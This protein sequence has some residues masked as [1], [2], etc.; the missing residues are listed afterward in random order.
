MRIIISGYLGRMGQIIDEAVAG[1]P[2]MEVVGGIDVKEASDA[3]VPVFSLP[4]GEDTPDADLVIDFS[5]FSLTEALMDFCIAKKIP[6]VVATTALGPD[7]K[8]ALAKAAETLPI[9][10]TANMSLGINLL[11]KMLRMASPS[12]ENDFNIEIV[13]KHHKM[14]ADA[15]SGTAVMLADVVN[16]SLKTPKNLL[17]GRHGKDYEPTMADLGIHA[18]RGGTMPGEHSIYFFGL[19]EVIELKHTVFSRKVFATG[20]LAAA[21]FI[22]K[23]Q[24]G[25]YNMDDVISAG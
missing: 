25:L 12:L 24:P 17:F 3:P 13:E 23:Q 6:A 18:V 15:P 20:A 14:K 10:N 5:N 2:D 22:V 11:A 8:A 19:D 4:A 21:R 16:E 1:D 7:Q 9:F